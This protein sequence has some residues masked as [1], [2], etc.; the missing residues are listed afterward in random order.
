MSNVLDRIR[1]MIGRECTTDSCSRDDCDVDMKTPHGKL[2]VVDADKAFPFF[3]IRG[4]KCD[5]VLFLEGA[6]EILVAAPVELKSGS[7][8]RADHAAE[9]LVAGAA[10]ADCFAP[11]DVD[12]VCVPILFH[13]GTLGHQRRKALERHKIE[14]RGRSVTIRTARCG[15]PRNLAAAL[16]ALPS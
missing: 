5:L 10:F 15:R 14:F 16:G 4:K 3:Q 8:I 1:D 11:P 6:N 12:V 9:Q 2:L 7:W 13:C